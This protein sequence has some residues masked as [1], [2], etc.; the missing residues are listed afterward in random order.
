MKKAIIILELFIAS[1]LIACNGKTD[2]NAD[3]HLNQTTNLTTSE[4]VVDFTK[5]FQGTINNKYEIEMNLTKKGSTVTGSYKYTTQN[6]SLTL[7]GTIDANG[8]INLSEF[9]SKGS[10]TGVFKGNLIGPSISGTWEKPDGSKSFPFK[11]SEQSVEK[12]SPTWAGNYIDEFGRVLTV[13]APKADGEISFS[14]VLAN[15]N[16]EEGEFSWKVYLESDNKAFGAQDDI[17]IQLVRDDDDTITIT[18]DSPIGT[19]GARCGDT[20]GTYKRKK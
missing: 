9:N 10:I 16:C 1:S 12:I 19:H 17:K 18:E 4:I 3:S 15:A 2:N 20:G 13:S 8:N 5:T 11:A 6:S 7:K 14:V